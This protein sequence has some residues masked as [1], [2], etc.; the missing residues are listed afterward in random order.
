MTT[1][2]GD[3]DERL[4][5]IRVLEIHALIAQQQRV[6][7]TLDVVGRDSTLAKRALDELLSMQRLR[8]AELAALR[9]KLN[10]P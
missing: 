7:R 8:E 5:D 10:K 6:I 4:L 1:A 9:K 2:T 3:S